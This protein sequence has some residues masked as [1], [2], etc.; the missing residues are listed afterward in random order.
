MKNTGFRGNRL[1][2]IGVALAATLPFLATADEGEVWN[3]TGTTSVEMGGAYWKSSVSG[4]TAAPT[5]GNVYRIP[6]DKEARISNSNCEFPDAQLL[7]EGTFS[8]K[9]GK[10]LT[11]PHLVA[12]SSSATIGIAG[13]VTGT[14][15]GNCTVA[16][17]AA[18]T[19]NTWNTKDSRN[20]V[21]SAAIKGTGA[22]AVL[23]SSSSAT[24]SRFV[25]FSGAMDDFTGDIRVAKDTGAAAN[26]T[27]VQAEFANEAFPGD[28]DDVRAAGV[29]VADGA[30]LKF[31]A[32]G[33]F[34]ENRGF[35][36]GSLAP[37]I[38]VELGKTVTIA[39][40][41]AGTAGFVKTGS[42]T[43]VLT[44]DAAGLS[45][46]VS[47]QGGLLR[48]VGFPNAA[49]AI[50]LDGAAEVIADKAIVLRATGYEKRSGEE[51]HVAIEVSGVE[52]G[53][54]CD[55]QWS[56]DGLNWTADEPQVDVAGVYSV[57]CQ[58]S[59]PGY[60]NG[61]AVARVLVDF[62]E[63]EGAVYLAPPGASDPQPPYA[64]PATAA[65]NFA[66]AVAAA[67]AGGLV[68]AASG[69]YVPMEQVV[70]TNVTVRGPENRLALVTGSGLKLG[71][72]ATISGFSFVGLDGALDLGT[73]AVAS[74]CFVKGCTAPVLLTGGTLADSEVC[75]F[76]G[77]SGVAANEKGGT[78]IGTSIHHGDVSVGA[79]R[80]TG[81]WG[82]LRLFDCQVCSNACPSSGTVGTFVSST[83]NPV[84][85]VRCRVIGNTGRMP[86]GRFGD[87]EPYYPFCA[88]NCLFA[89]NVSTTSEALVRGVGELVNCTIT[90]NRARYVFCC[91]ADGFKMLNTVIADNENL[92]GD[93]DVFQTEGGKDFVG[94]YEIREYSLFPGATGTGNLDAA[95]R[96]EGAGSAEPY[97]LR[98]G[99]PGVN[100]G[101]PLAWRRTDR[102]LSGASRVRGGRVDMG[103]FESASGICIVI[104]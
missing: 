82:T 28:P 96:F 39:G 34:G 13:A 47:V 72:G 58:A 18:L 12:N 5:A 74:N 63:T 104:R 26:T 81:Q 9:G 7:L 57:Y 44:G 30:T 15:A 2:A 65:D 103:C 89:G 83:G 73:G 101:A 86:I 21:V 19:L 71:A 85:L 53:V 98:C 37:T 99:S 77:T 23:G 66:D 10:T 69:R 67:G 29:T 14:L 4:E 91:D 20:L 40:P 64:T 1:A 52:A 100:A 75:D 95:A 27:P 25:R 33:A 78:I 48:H 70:L 102:D 22:L 35:D 45:G 62:E 88:T 60:A 55:Y 80:K 94:K 6:S 3:F 93:F 43:L 41:L 92:K 46:T 11:A 49:I 24:L 84:V 59:A 31:T 50:G 38:Y 17:G 90:G 56:L 42:G 32:S 76:T 36:F 79:V 8:F 87:S 16:D 61:Q 54:T 51:R 97:R 68:L